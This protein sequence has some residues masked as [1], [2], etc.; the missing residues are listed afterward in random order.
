MHL[1]PREHIKPYRENLDEAPSRHE[2]F[3]YL[4]RV[5]AVHGGDAE[6]GR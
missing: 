5:G 6:T 1:S 2:N 4:D 3:V